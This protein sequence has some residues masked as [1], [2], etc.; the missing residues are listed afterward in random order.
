MTRRLRNIAHKDTPAYPSKSTNPI[1]ISRERKDLTHL[2]DP[3]KPPTINTQHKLHSNRAN[4]L[5][6]SNT[7]HVRYLILTVYMT[8]ISEMKVN[9]TTKGATTLTSLS[10]SRFTMKKRRISSSTPRTSGKRTPLTINQRINNTT[11]SNTQTSNES[12]HL[13]PKSLNT[14]IIDIYR[15]KKI[16]I[17]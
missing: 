17:C 13:S 5:S 6:R 10:E 7:T 8:L 3:R 12:P 1:R 4:R 11:N 14:Q 9:G 2:K 16:P 15:P